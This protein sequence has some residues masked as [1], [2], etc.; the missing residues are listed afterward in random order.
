MNI[1][2]LISSISD[3][4]P[5]SELRIRTFNN[6]KGKLNDINNSVLWH[7]KSINKK[8]FKD[9]D[10]KDGTW[11]AQNN[12]QTNITTLDQDNE[13][14]FQIKAYAL[15]KLFTGNVEGGIGLK[16]STVAGHTPIL[17]NLALFLAKKKFT[18]FHQFCKSPQIII[19]NTLN[20]YLFKELKAQEN[21][22]KM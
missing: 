22:P 9:V 6:V 19:S 11:Y 17:N 8:H 5:S 3:P 13:F 7:T 16:T 4:L 14:S 15:L 2:E 21:L 20:E 18:S 1:H 12:K 10:F